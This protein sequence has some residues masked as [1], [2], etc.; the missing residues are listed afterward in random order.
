MTVEFAEAVREV[1]EKVQKEKGVFTKRVNIVHK[2]VR[3]LP[4]LPQLFPETDQADWVGFQIPTD[5]PM[6]R[7]PDTT[8][9]KESIGW[10]PKFTVLAGVE[11]MVRY[12][13]SKMEEGSI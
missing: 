2:E 10:Q 8:R 6:R 7:R 11:E 1:V 4:L 3:F 12:Y 5:D 13:D 9:A